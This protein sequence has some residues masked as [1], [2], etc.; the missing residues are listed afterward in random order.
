MTTMPID[1]LTN[2][3][4]NRRSSTYLNET[5][6]SPDT[7]NA[8]QFGKLFDRTVDGDV[9]AQP[10]V[11]SGVTI[12]KNG[13]RP[14]STRNVV[15]VATTRN[16]VYAFDADDPQEFEPL[17][18]RNF[19]PP[20][21]REDLSPV[22]GSP[23]LN[24]SS[25]I[26]MVGTPVIRKS[27]A[28][29][30]LYFIAKTKT[31]YDLRL[32]PPLDDAGRLPVRE[33][34]MIVLAPIGVMLHLRI[35]DDKGEL[36]LDA[37]EAAL[38]G[39]S[40][41][42]EE[43]KQ[44]IQKLGGNLM[45][46][47]A[48]KDELIKAVAKIVASVQD[49]KKRP[50]VTPPEYALTL[51]ALDIATG[52]AAV[53]P[54]TGKSVAPRTIDT[55]VTATLGNT[56]AFDPFL[57]QNR[58]GLLLMKDNVKKDVVYSAYCSQGDAQPFYGW[59]LAHDA[60][61]LELLATHCTTPDWGEGGIWQS[62]N[63]IAGDDQGFVYYVSGN[64]A[65]DWDHGHLRSYH[66]FL[67]VASAPIP[68]QTEFLEYDILLL[69]SAD[70]VAELS[71]NA[72]AL[73]ILAG[74]GGVLHFGIF[75][76]GGN[77]ILGIEEKWSKGQDAAIAGLRQQ[78]AG[79]WDNKPVKIQDQDKKRSIIQAILSIVAPTLNLQVKP[80]GFGCSIVKLKFSRDAKAP[81]N[82][83]FAVADFYTPSNTTAGSEMVENA[84]AAP[85]NA[86]DFDLCAGPVL[87]R[88][89]DGKGQPIDLVAGGGKNGRLYVLDRADL[90]KW[91][92]PQGDPGVQVPAYNKQAL[93]EDRLCHFH[94]HGAPVIWE[95]APQGTV[96][97]VWSEQDHLRAYAWDKDTK[98]FGWN[99]DAKTFDARPIAISE[100]GFAEGVMLMPGG[101]IA[102]S[103]D[104]KDPKTGIVWASHPTEDANN[105]TVPGVLRAFAA[106]DP[107][108]RGN[109][110]FLRE[111]WNSEHDPLK[112]DRVGMFAKFVPPVVANGKVYLATFSRQLVVYGELPGAKHPNG[113]G[114]GMAMAMDMSGDGPKTDQFYQ[115]TVGNV[116]VMGSVTGTCERL[117]LLAAG[118]DIAG[119]SDE[120]Q[121]Y[122]QVRKGAETIEVVALVQA[123]QLDDP[124]TKAGVMIRVSPGDNPK[125]TKDRLV[126]GS[127]HGSMLLTADRRPAF[128]S[129]V[130]PNATAQVMTGAPIPKLP[131]WVRVRSKPVQGQALYEVTGA[132]SSD[133]QCWQTVGNPVRLPTLNQG[134]SSDVNNG[135]LKLQAGVVLAA[136]DDPTKT[137]DDLRVAS[138]REVE[139]TDFQLEPPKP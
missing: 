119:T 118:A 24:F 128:I 125:G 16:W 106:S 46:P 81:K 120:F 134:I 135:N 3:N 80:P 123:I 18:A 103:A 100:F 107:V 62:G 108:T 51:H 2:R 47:V 122:G 68:T 126:P 27:G 39:Q 69:T 112:P 63:G 82:S 137:L 130:T 5:I 71:K 43:L 64:G 74:L 4:D 12:P 111:L 93:Q 55:S 20:M 28:G 86:H 101:F 92:A 104:G 139:I 110:T 44:R 131:Y 37:D 60:D 15:Y 85:L 132:I 114:M 136:H 61:T 10:L 102:V 88:A 113:M 52:K 83:S 95:G 48:L 13:S 58:A 59:V 115:Q 38:K 99:H 75:D 78:V 31:R 66:P 127:P 35:F 11:V 97:Y 21:P 56:I 90:G 67:R 105:A 121:F 22:L 72:R 1:V 87:F 42:V 50:R 116:Q 17:W 96:A 25:E 41:A 40:A 54:A 133:G 49:G 19:G 6:L 23:F 8:N 109:H 76:R 138:F 117:V 45:P 77:M 34:R 26:G 94:V 79:L 65:S 73:F 33:R 129:R 7:V 98:K 14:A 32:M 36:I 70:D 91:A 30:T 53:N 84:P 57:N 124:E 29:G 9:Y 89:P